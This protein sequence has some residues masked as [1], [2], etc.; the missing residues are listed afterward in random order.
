MMPTNE[1]DIAFGRVYG[2]GP[3]DGP[4]QM[5]KTSVNC[6][7]MCVGSTFGRF[8]FKDWGTLAN[9]RDG[10]TIIGCL[11][12]GNGKNKHGLECI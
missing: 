4:I 11:F 8:I 7:V 2:V 12:L 9:C 3:D 6:I 10:S 1:A 5:P